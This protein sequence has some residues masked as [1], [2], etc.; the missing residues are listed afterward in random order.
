[1]TGADFLFVLFLLS[2]LGIGFLAGRH[3]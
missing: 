2:A 1:M 3:W